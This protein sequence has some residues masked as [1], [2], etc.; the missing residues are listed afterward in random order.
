VLE[1]KLRTLIRAYANSALDRS[2]F[3]E[4]FADLYF[5]V[6]QS[7]PG[8]EGPA[9]QICSTVIGPLAELSRGHRTE[10][11]FLEVLR[12]INAAVPSPANIR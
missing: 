10:A 2:A 9:R 6:H 4:Q 12:G 7:P 1:A 3:S 5:S 8:H 11:S